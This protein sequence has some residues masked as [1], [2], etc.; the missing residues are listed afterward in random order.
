MGNGRLA[1]RRGRQD[2]AQQY[3]IIAARLQF[4]LEADTLPNDI[5]QLVQQAHDALVMALA[6]MRRLYAPMA[7]AA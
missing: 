2:R 6:A 4:H 1:K 5:A 7:D 3:A